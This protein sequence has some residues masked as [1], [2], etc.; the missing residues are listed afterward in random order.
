MM[1]CYLDPVGKDFGT[2]ASWQVV[3]VRPEEVDD[4][5]GSTSPKAP[6]AHI[7]VRT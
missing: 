4:C 5:S 2:Q 7:V 3:S 6:C 1:I